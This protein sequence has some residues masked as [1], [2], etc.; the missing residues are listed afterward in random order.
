MR[1]GLT[2]AERRVLRGL[3]DIREPEQIAQENGGRLSIVR[4]QIQSI[5]GRLGVRSI[6]ELLCRVAQLPLVASCMG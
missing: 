3:I 6:D 1:H 5:R 2:L 4:T